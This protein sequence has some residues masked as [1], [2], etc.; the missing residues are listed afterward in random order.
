MSN[1]KRICLVS[2]QFLPHVG[3]VENYVDNL[4]MTVYA[5]KINGTWRIFNCVNS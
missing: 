2:A 4:S 1:K 3:G 5:H